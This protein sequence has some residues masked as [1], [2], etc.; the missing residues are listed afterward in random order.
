MKKD[1]RQ[2]KALLKPILQNVCVKTW[3]GISGFAR[4]GKNWAFS[5]KHADFL[6]RR[7]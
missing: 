4:H 2:I 5:D 3:L 1:T 6:G 7:Q